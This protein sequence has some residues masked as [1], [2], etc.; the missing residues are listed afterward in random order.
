MCL[1]RTSDFAESFCITDALLAAAVRGDVE[2]GLFYTGQ[3]IVRI[4]ERAL[5]DLPAVREILSGLEGRLAARQGDSRN[6]AA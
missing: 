1:C 4:G 2:N 6:A 3:S 5:G